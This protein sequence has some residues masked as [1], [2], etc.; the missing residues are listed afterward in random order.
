MPAMV[1]ANGPRAWVIKV[2]REFTYWSV[3]MFWTSRSGF[4]WPLVAVNGRVASGPLRA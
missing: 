1:D 4:P 3:S 2:V